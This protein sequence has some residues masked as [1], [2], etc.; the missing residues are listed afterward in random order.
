M[1]HDE[2]M[3]LDADGLRL[4]V[5]RVLGYSGLWKVENNKMVMAPNFPRDIAAAEKLVDLMHADD[6]GIEIHDVQHQLDKV[7][8]DYEGT[9]Y[10]P[11]GF[12]AEEYPFTGATMA[13]AICRAYLMFAAWKAGL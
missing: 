6:C 1:T 10:C 13:E 3:A 4:E 12:G 8:W 11:I 2:I 5:A 9:L 7:H